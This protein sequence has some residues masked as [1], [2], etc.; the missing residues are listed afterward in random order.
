[1]PEHFFLERYRAAYA[2]EMAHFFDALA[3][4]T[5]VRTSIEDGVKALELADA[6]THVVARKAH[7]GALTMDTVRSRHRRPRPHGPAPRGESRA[8]ACPAQRSWR[9]AAR[10]ARSSTG[11]A[12][13]SASRGAVQ[14]L[15]ATCWRDKDVDAVF[16][17]T[18][19]TL[20][21]AQIID[22][23]AAPAS[24]CSARSRCRW[25]STNACGRGG[26]R[27]ASA[28]QGDDRLRA[29]LRR[30]LP[31]RACEHRVG[32]DRPAVPRALANAATRTT[33]RAS[34]SSSRRRPAASSST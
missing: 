20:H 9:R 21:P 33:R 15:R 10:S 1:M 2:L 24:T 8:R 6:A 30:E 29:P 19:N 23:A 5:P 4:G 7:R 27:E 34:S 16:L 22:G 31:G 26:G 32:R 25:C 17:V 14:G 11:R 3:K 18:P 28:S 13:R 12:T